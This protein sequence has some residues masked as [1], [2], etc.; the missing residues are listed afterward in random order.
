MKFNL[1]APCGMFLDVGVSSNEF[2]VILVC[3]TDVQNTLV[4]SKQ[5]KLNFN[6]QSK[7]WDINSIT[8][9]YLFAILMPSKSL[10][11]KA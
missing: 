5:K 4:V 11:F 1:C 2:N 9:L 3:E 8:N 10:L 7:Q 6:K